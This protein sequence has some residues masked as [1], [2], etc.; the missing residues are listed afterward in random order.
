MGLIYR[1]RRAERLAIWQRHQHFTLFRTA[2]NMA[3]RALQLVIGSLSDGVV[4]SDSHPRRFQQN[5]YFFAFLKTQTLAALREL[6]PEPELALDDD[7]EV[8]AG[9]QAR[10][11]LV[12]QDDGEAAEPREE[13]SFRS[14][15]A[16]LDDME[17]GLKTDFDDLRLVEDEE[18]E[19]VE[20][21][22]A[23]LDGDQPLH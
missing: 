22:L 4:L 20:D 2:F 16:E 6:E 13:T 17:Q 14:L 15:L 23:D 12:L 8:P 9:L 10:A 19:A 5:Q 7:A 1:Q 3:N 18:D 11:D 21:D